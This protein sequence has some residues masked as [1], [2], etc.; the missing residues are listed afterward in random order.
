M[1]QSSLGKITTPVFDKYDL[2][3]EICFEYVI[4][5]PFS[6]PLMSISGKIQTYWKSTSTVMINFLFIY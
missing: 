6:H 4:I 3:G 5:N 2:T 1:F